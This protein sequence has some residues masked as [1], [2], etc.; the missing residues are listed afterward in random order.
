MRAT[1][2]ERMRACLVLLVLSFLGL[3]LSPLLSALFAR[4][5]PGA[6]ARPGFVQIVLVGQILPHFLFGV[7]LGVAASL[8]LQKSQLVSVLSVALV[9]AVE[10]IRMI[11]FLNGNLGLIS[12]WSIASWCVA[13]SGAWLAAY[14]ITMARR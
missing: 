4:L 12:V 10:L 13:M 9:G 7:L 1:T 11:V 2:F 8:L 6:P 3:F 5:V 14:G